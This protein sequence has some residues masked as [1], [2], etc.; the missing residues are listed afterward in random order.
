MLTR[1]GG[2]RETRSHHNTPVKCSLRHR[3]IMVQRFDL[4]RNVCI[5]GG[6]RGACSVAYRRHGALVHS[7]ERDIGIKNALPYLLA[8]IVLHFLLPLHLLRNGFCPSSAQLDRFA[9]KAY[10]RTS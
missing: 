7:G 1:V 10:H 4:L 2:S 9:Q 5:S 8:R 3:G 6:V